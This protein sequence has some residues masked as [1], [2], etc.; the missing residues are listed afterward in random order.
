METEYGTEKAYRE[1]ND[2]PE[3]PATEPETPVRKRE[4]KNKELTALKEQ[5]AAVARDMRTYRKKAGLSRAGFLKRYI[6]RLDEI[7]R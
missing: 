5:V 2:T 6:V 7:A 3:L 4:P 1:Q